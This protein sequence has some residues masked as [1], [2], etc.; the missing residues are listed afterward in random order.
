TLYLKPVLP[1]LADKA[2]R[3][4]NI[5]P[6]QWQDHQQ[7]LLGHEIN[8]FKP[9]MQRIDRKQIEA[10]TADA[11]A[12]AEAEAAAGKPKGP[13]GDD[14]IADQIT[15]DDFAKID[16]RVA[17]IVTASHVEG[18]DK[19]IQL[20]LDLGGETRNVFAGIKS[21]YQPQDLEGRLTIMV[22]N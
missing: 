3:F 6:L 4:L 9:M 14:P 12:D 21:A 7:L 18:A 1:D 5:E 13:L 16:M 17:K 2:E 10:M 20:T 11:K 15:F 8:K 22:A 19:L